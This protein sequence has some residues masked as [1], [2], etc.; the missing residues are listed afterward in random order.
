M[1]CSSA[2]AKDYAYYLL[3]YLLYTE[4]VIFACVE[5]V[6]EGKMKAREK[7]VGGWGGLRTT[8]KHADIPVLSLKE[9]SS[10]L[11]H[12]LLQQTLRQ[13][14]P[15]PT[16]SRELCTHPHTPTIYLQYTQAWQ[17]GGKVVIY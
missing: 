17:N 12:Q 10:H 13:A 6:S 1:T 5:T 7:E 15:T 4:T 8:V 11:H 3:I 14:F 9:V 2:T 16:H